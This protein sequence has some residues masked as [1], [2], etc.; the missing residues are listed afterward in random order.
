[1]MNIRNEFPQLSQH[2]E[3]M[4]YLDSAAT[5]L[6]P[7]G[8]IEAL[9]QH[10]SL[11]T[12][13]VHRGA[14]KWSDEAT[15]EFENARSKVAQFLGSKAEEIIFTRGTTESINLVASSLTQGFKEGDEILLTQMEHHS[16]IVPWQLMA[17]RMK[18][19]L[20][21]IPVTDSGELDLSQIKSLLTARTKV[22]S[23]VYISNSLG[24][25]NPIEEVILAARKVG[26][27]VVLDAAQAVSVLPIDVKKL[28][29]DFLAFSGHKL[30][31]PT[32]IGVL[33]GKLDL[34]KSL[35]PYQGGG[36]M[37]SEVFES[38]S[39]FLEP[40]HRFEAGTPAI[41]EAIALRSAIEF[42]TQIGFNKIQSHKK[43]LLSAAESE[44]Q[45]IP[46]LKILS[47]AQA[48]ANIVSFNILG[49]HPSDVGAIL[50]QQGVAVRAGHHCC[51][52]L[53][54]RFKIPGTV[55]ASFSVYNTLSDV[56]ALVNAVKKASEILL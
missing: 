22:V 2:Q 29:C 27:Y 55:R 11:K 34:L 48:K 4:V 23:L 6:K 33:F 43:Q 53:M 45:E 8:V 49:A 50:N 42:V 18:L 15:T 5:T 37:I 24:T 54:K 20:K 14:H 47:R 16:N 9:V 3:P 40:P 28:D 12:S 30:F 1:M 52:P 13:N 32:G 39:T 17:E 21:Y 41:A 19:V 46:G 25:I 36:S 38:H 10:Y 31:G 26:A 51:Q 35:P 56:K 7:K 44:L